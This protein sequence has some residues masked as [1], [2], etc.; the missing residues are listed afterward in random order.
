MESTLADIKQLFNVK[1]IAYA[2]KLDAL[3]DNSFAI[4]EEG[5]DT[6]VASTV[7]ANTLPEKIRFLAKVNG[8]L[9][10]SFDTINKKDIINVKAVDYKAPVVNVWETTITAAQCACIEMLKIIVNIE[11]MR[12]LNRDGLTWQHRDFVI[13]TTPEELACACEGGVDADP[14]AV[15]NKMTALLVKKVID[16]DSEFYTAKAVKADGSAITGDLDTFVKTN[17]ADEAPVLIKLVLEGKPHAAA[18]YKD[19]DTDWVGVRGVGLKPIVEVNNG[20]VSAIKFTETQALVYEQGAGADL[21]KEEWDNMNYYTN[22]NYRTQMCDGLADPN[23]VYQFENGQN[24]KTVNFEFTTLNTE[25]NSGRKRLFGVLLGTTDNTI[26][27]QLKA[28]FGAA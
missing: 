24:Y 22:L 20:D 17:L 8:K 5:S 1:A 4:Y 9:Y 15:N 26:F 14:V 25:R 6:S 18:P 16:M 7:T 28:L 27:T 21:R 10:Y 19:L 13:A 2:T 23:L 3:P 11:D 12:L